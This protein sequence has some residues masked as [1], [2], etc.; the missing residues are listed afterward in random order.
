MAGDWI[1]STTCAM[2]RL[3]S[4]TPSAREAVHSTWVAA[5]TSL[6][7]VRDFC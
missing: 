3:S 5:C 6:S 2:R 1:R 7:D 4:V